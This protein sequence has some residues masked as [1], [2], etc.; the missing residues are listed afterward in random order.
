MDVKPAGVNRQPGEPAK[1]SLSKN[2]ANLAS[3][4]ETLS[5]EQ[6]KLFE[7]DDFAF[8][9]VNDE[10]ISANPGE[11]K[12]NWTKK[13]YQSLTGKFQVDPYIAKAFGLK[14]DDCITDVKTQEKTIYQEKNCLQGIKNL[15]NLDSITVTRDGKSIILSSN[16]R[17]GILP[18]NLSNE[19]ITEWKPKFFSRKSKIKQP[20]SKE[21]SFLLSFLNSHNSYR[22]NRGS[23]HQKNCCLK[24]YIQ[25]VN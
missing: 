2:K 3:K 15:K 21:I 6:L 23:P 1:G 18:E 25:M 14:A 24:D 16:L 12:K 22:E 20:A 11:N 9:I 17:S 4:I 5:E 7:K 19:I 13:N 8:L 10:I